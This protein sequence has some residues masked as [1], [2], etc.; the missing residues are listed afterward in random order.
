MCVPQSVVAGNKQ[1]VYKNI[2]FL[3]VECNPL[4]HMSHLI[5][6]FVHYRMIMCTY[7]HAHVFIDLIWH[8]HSQ[9][10]PRFK[11]K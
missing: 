7:W 11:K 6:L 4:L 10:N 3:H 8:R 5:Y 2:I 1:M 9:M